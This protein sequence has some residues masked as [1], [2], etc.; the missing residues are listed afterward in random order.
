MNIILFFT[1]DI[2]LK[3]WEKSGLLDREIEFYKKLHEK[4]NVYFTFLTFGDIEDSKIIDLPY[5]RVEPIYKYIKYEKNKTLRFLKS[6][7]I[8]IK[9]KKLIKE[10]NLIKTNQLLGSW[11]AII[12]KILYGKSLIIR[13]G[14]D[15]LTFSK[16]NKK[17]RIKIACYS[18]LTRISLIFANIYLVSSEADKEFL[19][20]LTRLGSSKIKVRPNWVKKNNGGNHN[21]RYKNKI[22]SVGRLENQKNFTQL[23][24][25]FKDSK[26]EIEIFGEGSMEN[27]L[28]DEAKK[29]NVKLKIHKPIPNNELLDVLT[30]YS[31]F[32]S[33]SSFEG[34][35]KA[36]LEA[37]A[38]GCVV[39][40]I[41]S[42]NITEIVE[43]NFNG[44]IINKKTDVKQ[45]IENLEQDH[46]KRLHL[47]TNAVNF[48]DQNYLLEKVVEK[49]YEDYILLD[50]S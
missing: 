33:T 23:I 21:K 27:Q 6:L 36:V 31:F 42:Q 9:L 18:V 3:D 2:S 13:T 25:F 29:N 8:P 45:L 32:I 4:Y 35:P 46:E 40:A 20:D 10:A 28:I 44:I 43:N 26:Y 17:S 22:I 47:S 50:S 34:N 37:M 16:K 38:A 1:Y 11:I 5:I 39:I 14:Y 19:C 30:H 12:S 49:E 24:S 41:E 15:L 48:I 7:F